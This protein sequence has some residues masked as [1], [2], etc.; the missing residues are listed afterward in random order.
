[1][2]LGWVSTLLMRVARDYLR[3]T[4]ESCLVTEGRKVSRPKDTRVQI[5]VRSAPTTLRLRLLRT[6]VFNR[7]QDN[8]GTDNGVAL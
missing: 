1:M 2:N 8:N 6:M 4:Y 3:G 7:P 5:L